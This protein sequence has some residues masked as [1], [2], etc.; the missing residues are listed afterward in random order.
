[1][2]RPTN[3]SVVF[4]DFPSKNEEVQIQKQEVQAS[5][6]L[7]ELDAEDSL[8]ISHL[9][10]DTSETRVSTRIWLAWTVALGAPL[11]G[12]VSFLCFCS[13]PIFQQAEFN[14]R[15]SSYFI[16]ARYLHL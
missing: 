2:W 12:G 7:E 8:T 11:Y 13:R 3:P 15:M 1:M 4:S 9:F 16:P 10:K 6:R 5:I 14:L